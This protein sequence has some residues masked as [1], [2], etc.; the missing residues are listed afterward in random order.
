MEVVPTLCVSM[1]CWAF[2]IIM[3]RSWAI[4]TSFEESNALRSRLG[5]RS[6]VGLEDAMQTSW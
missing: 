2:P 3:R 5:E 1:F 4:A 6:R